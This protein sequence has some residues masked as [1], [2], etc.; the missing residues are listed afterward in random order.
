MLTPRFPPED[1]GVEDADGDDDDDGG[2]EDEDG[3]VAAGVVPA[4]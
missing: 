1:G 2:H 4:Q 3:G